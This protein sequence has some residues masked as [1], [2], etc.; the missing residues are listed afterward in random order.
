MCNPMLM[1]PLIHAV[2]RAA[3][4][5]ALVTLALPQ[6]VAAQSYPDRTVRIIVP[7]APGGSI[8]TTARV[9]AAKLSDAWGKPVVIENRPGRRHGDRRRGGGE[10]AA[11][12]LHAA[13]GA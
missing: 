2:R 3:L 7:T 6:C 1:C 9:V 8:D 11:R 4:L 10:V 5:A 13:G 12:R